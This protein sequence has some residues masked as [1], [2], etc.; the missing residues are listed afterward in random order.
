MANNNETKVITGKVRFSYA[1]VFEPRKNDDGTE[2]YS[3]S[4]LI[5]K[6]DTKTIYIRYTQQQAQGAEQ[7]T[8]VGF[9]LF[10]KCCALAYN[11]PNKTA[12]R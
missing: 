4:L 2:K 11:I 10:D 7:P 1:N 5:D 9:F 12:G 8:G 6:D 3:V